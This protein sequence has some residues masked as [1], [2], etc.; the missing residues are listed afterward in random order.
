MDNT[1]KPI[2]KRQ[3]MFVAGSLGICFTVCYFFG[4]MVALIVNMVLFAGILFY[5]RK[6][7]SAL[8]SFGFGDEIERRTG[9]SW[10]ENAVPKVRYICVSCGSEVKDIVQCKNCGS[11]T[12]KPIF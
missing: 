10:F 9:F 2:I 12:K 7:Q 4:F 11:K 3:L 8:R 6:K 1:A 5:I